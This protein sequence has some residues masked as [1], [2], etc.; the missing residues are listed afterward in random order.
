FVTHF[1]RAPELFKM[2]SNKSKAFHGRTSMRLGRNLNLFQIIIFGKF[3]GTQPSYS[4]IDQKSL[5]NK[6]ME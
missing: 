3:T 6:T 5:D 1:I 4:G 2:L